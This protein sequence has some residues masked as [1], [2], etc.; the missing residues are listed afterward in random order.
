MSQ[1]KKFIAYIVNVLKAQKE[2]KKHDI[3]DIMQSIEN[4]RSK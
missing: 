2:E 1:V 3:S 4:R